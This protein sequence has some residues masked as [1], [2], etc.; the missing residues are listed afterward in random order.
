MNIEQVREYF[1]SKPGVVEERPFKIP[2]PVFKIG[3]KMFGLI[4]VHEPDRAS[5]N[6][7]NNKEENDILRQMYDE[8]TPGYHMNK[9]HWNTIYIDGDLEDDFIKKLIDVSYEIVFKSLPKKKQLQIQ[10]K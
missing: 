4:N 6:L 9:V 2:V 3:D 1:H 8:I 5:I 7:K 10:N